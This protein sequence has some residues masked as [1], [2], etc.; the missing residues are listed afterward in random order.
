MIRLVHPGHLNVYFV[1]VASYTI[2]TVDYVKLG[3]YSLGVTKY[4]MFLLNV[5]LDRNIE[6]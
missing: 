2:D 5:T 6:V 1:I 3:D 4:N